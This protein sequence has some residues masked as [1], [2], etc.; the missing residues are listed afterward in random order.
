MFLVAYLE[1]RGACQWLGACA[2]RENDLA[3]MDALLHLRMMSACSP[4][5]AV[6]DLLTPEAHA[7]MKALFHEWPDS[8]YP[9][10]LAH[11][12][13]AVALL[14]DEYGAKVDTPR[15]NGF[16]ALMDACAAGESDVARALCAR[17]ADVNMRCAV[18]DCVMRYAERCR[19]PTQH[20]AWRGRSCESAPA[21]DG[22]ACVR[23][24]EEF[25]ATRAGRY[26]RS[27]W[28]SS[29]DFDALPSEY[30]PAFH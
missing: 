5:V 24:L 26:T 25:G 14:C 1:W 28:Y 18:G 21:P 8:V 16:T 9:L 22:A 15:A 3:T 6:S 10:H 30:I 20:A 27:E 17:G 23:V 11:S 7:K 2:L 13:E 4:L 29:G 12:H 19:D